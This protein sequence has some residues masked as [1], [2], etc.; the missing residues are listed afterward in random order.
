M[1]QPTTLP[2]VVEGRWL[3]MTF[4]E[5]LAWAPDGVQAEWVAGKGIIH[6]SNSTRHGRLLDFLIHLLRAYLR[7][8]GLGEV[9]SSTVLLRLPGRPA[10]RMPDLFVVRTEHRDRIR[11][12]W[13]EG[14]ADLVVELLSEESA[15]R[16]RTEKL[17]EYETAG[18]PEYVMVDVREGQRGF[19]YYRLD[20][21]GRYQAVAPDEQ[22]RYHSLVLP[23][24]WLDPNWLWQDP[25][26]DVEDVLLTVAPDAYEAW[27]MAKLRAR[28]RAASEGE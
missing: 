24:F 27:I 4:E 6:V 23:G 19:E 2:P 16:D 18:V 10:G 13:C 15:A 5:F 22:G 9:F 21:R 14:P 1:A 17:P 20:E 26:P 7:L 8:T 25:L 3:P 12:Q 11:A 28:R